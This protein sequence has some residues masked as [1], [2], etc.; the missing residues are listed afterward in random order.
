MSFYH[1]CFGK[2]YINLKNNCTCNLNEPNLIVFEKYFVEQV[3]EYLYNRLIMFLKQQNA[4]IL[5]IYYIIL[6]ILQDYN[7]FFTV[8]CFYTCFFLLRNL[9]LKHKSMFHITALRL[10][11]TLKYCLKRSINIVMQTTILTNKI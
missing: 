9:M 10:Y 11:D 5:I 3:K 7:F 1:T 8:Y 6:K 4:H 2:L